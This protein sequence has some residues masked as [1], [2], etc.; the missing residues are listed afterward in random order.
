MCFP[1][2]QELFGTVKRAIIGW[3]FVTAVTMSVPNLQ[4]GGRGSQVTLPLRN[5]ACQSV[6]L[7]RRIISGG[8]NPSM[9]VHF[10][11]RSIQRDV[12]IA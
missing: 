4:E 2:K 1:T 12:S 10:E 7:D 9:L 6:T 11:H 3:A 8:L 5:L